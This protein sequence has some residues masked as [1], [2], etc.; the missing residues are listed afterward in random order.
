MFQTFAGFKGNF[1]VLANISSPSGIST[2]VVPGLQSGSFTSRIITKSWRVFEVKRA[3]LEVI[4]ILQS[5]DIIA[6]CVARPKLVLNWS[7]L[8]TC[9]PSIYMHTWAFCNT[10]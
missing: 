6:A 8:Q 10:F 9:C 5:E 7:S 1:F 4:S 2:I 3:E